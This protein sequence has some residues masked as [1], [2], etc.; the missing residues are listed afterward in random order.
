VRSGVTSSSLPP[1]AETKRETRDAGRP[2]RRPPQLL[3]R[4]RHSAG[5]SRA[6]FLAR[7]SSSPVPSHLAGGPAGQWLRPG[8]SPLTAAGQRGL[9]T[10]FPNPTEVAPAVARVLRS[11]QQLAIACGRQR[12][13][14]LCTERALL[15]GLAL[16]VPSRRLEAAHE[17]LERVGRG[18]DALDGPGRRSAHRPGGPSPASRSGLAC[19]RSRIADDPRRSPA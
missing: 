10:P 11:C 2:G 16:D 1:A 18:E 6:G 14:A 8:S 12:R 19:H 13:R 7:G 15:A 4:G 17:Q 5:V 9:C 3:P